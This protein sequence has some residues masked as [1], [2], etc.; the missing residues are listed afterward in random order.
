MCLWY[1]PHAGSTDKKKEKTN[2]VIY[3]SNAS[4]YLSLASS[5]YSMYLRV[6]Y[7]EYSTSLYVWYSVQS[8][9]M[10]DGIKLSNRFS[11]HAMHKERVK[12][13]YS[14]PPSMI[15]YVQLLKCGTY[16]HNTLGTRK[17]PWIK[18]T[19]INRTSETAR[20]PST[21]HEPFS[22]SHGM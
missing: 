22:S 10:L 21:Y 9:S 2:G 8:K 16:I 14:T 18:T 11:L 15:L 1:Q 19:P 5:I 4:W 13:K 20:L 7:S 6:E 17:L 3:G 12:H